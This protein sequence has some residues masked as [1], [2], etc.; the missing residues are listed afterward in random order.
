M[1]HGC[2]LH[3]NIHLQIYLYSLVLKRIFPFDIAWHAKTA[4]LPCMGETLRRSLANLIYG[5]SEV[6][7]SLDSFAPTYN[8]FLIY[9]FWWFLLLPPIRIEFDF[10]WAIPA[11]SFMYSF[12]YYITPVLGA[13]KILYNDK[14][15]RLM[16]NGWQLR[17]YLH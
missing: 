16:N 3:R 7:Y 2:C 4:T 9:S 13:S 8:S 6:F 14:W 5:F 15:H 11:M 12:S 10:Q 1:P 17:Y